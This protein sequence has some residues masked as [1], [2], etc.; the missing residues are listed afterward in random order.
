MTDA[1]EELEKKLPEI[2]TPLYVPS[3]NVIYT[4]DT[5]ERIRR[6]A[7]E[8]GKI[9]GNHEILI[10]EH[11]AWMG[12]LSSIMDNNDLSEHADI[13]SHINDIMQA[14][15]S[16]PIFITDNG[17]II[18]GA[19][20]TAK[21]YLYREMVKG[22][23]VSEEELQS[24]L[25]AED[26]EYEGQVY[27]DD[28]GSYYAINKLSSICNS[29]QYGEFEPVRL[30]VN[31]ENIWGD[32]KIIEVVD[33]IVEGVTLE[34]DQKHAISLQAVWNAAKSYYPNRDTSEDDEDLFKGGI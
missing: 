12:S 9:I 25:L 24:T 28:L 3:E 8:Y 23:M 32:I 26:D 29:K 22:I 27:G 17:V 10:A 13:Q 7:T 14:E 31:N 1:F 34:S 11:E 5:R 16:I 4:V 20:R 30:L 15:L 18:D 19:H 2:T 33:M 21:A 6:W